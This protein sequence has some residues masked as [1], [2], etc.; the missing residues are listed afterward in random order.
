MRAEQAACNVS[1]VV[2]RSQQ[3]SFS[4]RKPLRRSL[5]RTPLTWFITFQRWHQTDLVPWCSTL[6]PLQESFDQDVSL[7]GL[8]GM[9]ALKRLVFQCVSML[10]AVHGLYIRVLQVLHIFDAVCICVCVCFGM[11]LDELKPFPEP[12]L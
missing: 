12:D 11:F 5:E 3:M 10:F 4:A 6:V 8:C 9:C 1:K 7:L 2:L